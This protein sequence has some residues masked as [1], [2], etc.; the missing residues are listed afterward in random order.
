M[1]KFPIILV[2]VFSSFFA[3]GQKFAYINTQAI[4]TGLPEVQ[5]ANANLE[6]FRNQ[7]VNL[8]K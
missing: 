6:T 4:L 3:F 2:L 7:L 8:G 1:K 5:Q